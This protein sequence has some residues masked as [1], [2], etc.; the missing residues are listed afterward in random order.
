MIA[1]YSKVP[2]FLSLQS[3]KKTTPK[4]NHVKY[5]PSS[6][7]IKDEYEL[8]QEKEG[9]PDPNNSTLQK[10]LSKKHSRVEEL[11]LTTERSN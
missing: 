1:S 5:D 2:F 11:E 7:E 9:R 6:A 4:N 10:R 3:G 8:M